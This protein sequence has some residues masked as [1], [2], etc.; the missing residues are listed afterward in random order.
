MASN[1]KI[2]T[3]ARNAMG[4]A[5]ITAIGTSAK[6][7][8]YDGSQPAGPGTAIS[9]Q[10]LLAEL[11]GNASAFAAATS[12]GV[13]TAN[14]I[15]QDSGADATGTATWYRILTSGSTAVWDGTVGTSGADLNLNTTSIVLA[16]PVSV[17]SMT[18]TMPGG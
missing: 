1:I 6:I 2:S 17:S 7:R 9:T 10:N 15:T 12:S 3:A 14:A 16:G 5:L 8:I 13:I 11:T 18:I 4:D